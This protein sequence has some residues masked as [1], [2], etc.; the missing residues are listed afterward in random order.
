MTPKIS[1]PGRQGVSSL[2]S[3]QV[4]PQSVARDAISAFRDPS[5]L[6]VLN[7]SPPQ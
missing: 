7:E 1:L 3:R 5:V 6:N 4:S 2:F